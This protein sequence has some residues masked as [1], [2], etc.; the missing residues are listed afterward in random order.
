MHNDSKPVIRISSGTI[1]RTILFIVLFWVLY[2]IKDLV[3]VVLAAVVIASSVEPASRWFMR[4]KVRRVPGVIIIY[5]LLLVLLAGFF[6]FFLPAVLNEAVVYLNN[7]P[8]DLSLNDLWSPIR[9]TGFFGNNVPAIGEGFAFKD[10]IDGLRT[11][12]AGTGAGVFKT[13][14]VI[15]GGALS[16]I[17]MIVLSFYLAVQEDGVGN[18]LKLITPLKSQKY[19]I[20]LW[21]RSQVKIG[22]WLQGQLLLGVIMGVLVYL[23]LTVIGIKHALLLASL[24]AIFELIPVF[25]PILSAIPAILIAMVDSGFGKGALVIIFYIIIHQFENHLFYPLV[26]K[27]IVGVSPIVVILSLVIGFKLA[28]FLGILLSVPVSAALMEYISDIERRKA[29]PVEDILV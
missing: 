8:S 29:M 28:G 4:H 9:D 25:G 20:D 6:L 22:Y 3:L 14:S 5:V 23:V 24:A 7:L 18:F 21:K 1:V 19:I 2:L 11:A 27:K 16:F 26:M 15:F 12:V 17:L 10:I 13:A